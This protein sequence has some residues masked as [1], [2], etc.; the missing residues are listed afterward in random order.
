MCFGD[1]ERL[2]VVRELD[3][4]G[5]LAVVEDFERVGRQV[6]HQPAVAILDRRVDRDHLRAA[7]ED[8]RAGGNGGRECDE[9]REELR[10]PNSA[11]L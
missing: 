9:Y 11:A 2:R 3:D 7:T 5:G 8:L 6:V 10:H 4:L 1:G